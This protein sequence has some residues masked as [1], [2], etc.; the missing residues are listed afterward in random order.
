MWSVRWVPV[1]LAASTLL[2]CDG[3][4]AV[5][6]GSSSS[7]FQLS[8]PDGNL[9]MRFKGRIQVD[10]GSVSDSGDATSD[11]TPTGTR[12]GT[13][14]D[15][16]VRSV[17]FGIQGEV[18]DWI[19]YKAGGI[20]A[21]GETKFTDT[22]VEADIH[23]FQVTL[24]H[25]REAVSM[26]EETGG[27]NV[28]FMERAAF[29]D[30]WDYRRRVGI[31]LDY[32]TRHL[33]LETA[34]QTDNISQ[35]APERDRYAASARLIYLPVAEKNRM[36]HLAAYAFLRRRERDS[37]GLGG[38]FVRYRQRPEIHP[39]DQR[40]VDTGDIPA[41]G[42]HIYGLEVAGLSGPLNATAE[43]SFL[44]VDP[45]TPGAPSPHLWGGYAEVGY[46]LTGE[47]RPYA[48]RQWAHVVPKSPLNRGGLGAVEILM[49]FDYL[50][51]EDR[52]AQVLGGRQTAYLLG[53]NWY[54]VDHVRLMANAA[55]IEIADGPNY[56]NAAGKNTLD[57]VGLRAQIDW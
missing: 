31:G 57:V 54:P 26:D 30:A 29:T 11:G 19:S 32:E 41:K 51:L 40:F 42:D 2:V 56:R 34:L 25:F 21:G 33:I 44:T 48:A 15:V 45:V 13:Q 9:T 23:H 1:L 28:N 53:V 39:I 20:R 16:E 46:F 17:Q 22:Y 50:D 52:A 37:G 49:R 5:A 3:Q 10:W 27:P 8:S 36:L 47:S 14:D 7:P 4:E 24:G 38:P 12:F 55:L 18:S 35:R 43:A 6:A